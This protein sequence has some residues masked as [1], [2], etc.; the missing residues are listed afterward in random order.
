MEHALLKLMHD[1][2]DSWWYRGRA[3]V[4]ARVLGKFMRKRAA[5]AI[6]IGAGYGGMRPTLER[7]ARTV[8]AVEPD[9]EARQFLTHVG[10]ARIFDTEEEA[11]TSAYDLIG[12]FDV[13]E[14]IED[15]AGFMRRV[16]AHMHTGGRV[17]L[18][19]PAYQWLW[20]SHDERNHH[21]RRYT[22]RRMITLLEH[23]DLK[24]E[25][26]G[27]WNMSLFPVA[28]L[29][30]LIGVP[31]ETGLRTGPLIDRILYGIVWIESLLARI[32]PLPFGLSIIAV[33]TPERPI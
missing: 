26:A 13:V 20:S 9:L 2:E 4:V 11:F 29:R 7:F 31:G 30:C 15:D 25:Y 17:V 19:V 8:D 16:G 32:M 5:H 22:R 10:Y 14:H 28:A 1:T 27:H 18:T 21:F 6:D 12:L 33:A 3:L 24:V 23:A